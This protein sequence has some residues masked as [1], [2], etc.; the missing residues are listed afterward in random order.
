M[1]M[2]VPSRSRSV[3]R[4]V[5]PVRA[6]L[7]R[8]LAQV[9]ELAQQRVREVVAADSGS[10]AASGTDSVPTLDL[11]RQLRAEDA[12]DVVQPRQDRIARVLLAAVALRGS[13]HRRAPRA[14]SRRVAPAA[15]IA[16][17][18]LFSSLASAANASLALVGRA[19]G[20]ARG[21]ARIH[22]HVGEAEDD[23]LRLRRP[24]R[25]SS[26][27]RTSEAGSIA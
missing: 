17:G 16:T 23:R 13:A 27:S 25:W 26:A 15:C 9:G 1:P 18:A 14:S 8:A 24:A 21:R 5:R 22:R 20:G 7:R 19:L 4:C 11:D 6:Q 3:N 12:V 2:V 10:L